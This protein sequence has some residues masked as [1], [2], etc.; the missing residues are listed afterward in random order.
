MGRRMETIGQDSKLYFIPSG[1]PMINKIKLSVKGGIKKASIVCED[2]KN[3]LVSKLRDFKEDEVVEIPWSCSFQTLTVRISSV[4]MM[5]LEM[6]NIREAAEN[7]QSIATMK[8]ENGKTIMNVTDNY[9]GSTQAINDAF[10]ENLTNAETGWIIG[11][12]ILGALLLT[13][14]SVFS[15][16]KYWSSRR[17]LTAGPLRMEMDTLE[18]L[19]FNRTMDANLKQWIESKGQSEKISAK[20]LVKSLRTK[21]GMTVQNLTNT[22]AVEVSDNTETPPTVV[23]HQGPAAVEDPGAVTVDV[24]EV[25]VRIQAPVFLK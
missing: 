17:T 8:F 25:Q 16:Y 3:G 24:K 7:H 14:V 18:K 1:N 6:T 2:D 15:C 11:G 10:E 20:L 9:L 13:G 12:A 21:Q 19:E 5:V 23:L 22:Q 4:R